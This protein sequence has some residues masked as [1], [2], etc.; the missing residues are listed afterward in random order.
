MNS[1]GNLDV[2][3]ALLASQWLGSTVPRA[4]G[5]PGTRLQRPDG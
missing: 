2:E 5:D 3:L 1:S 4:A